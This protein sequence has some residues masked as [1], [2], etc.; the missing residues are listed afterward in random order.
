MFLPL[1]ITG[2][3]A[4]VPD[5]LGAV[6]GGALLSHWSVS[7]VAVFTLTQGPPFVDVKT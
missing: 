3:T 6:T 7:C 5:E 2:Q 1:P 4:E